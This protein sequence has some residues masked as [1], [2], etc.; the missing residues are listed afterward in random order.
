[1]K[2]RLTTYDRSLSVPVGYIG[3]MISSIDAVELPDPPQ[4]A[5]VIRLD[6]PLPSGE[7]IGVPFISRD[8]VCFLAD[9]LKS[10][11]DLVWPKEKS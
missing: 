4:L 3:V 1:M 2:S 6:I 8:E 5:V 9:R 11:A 10:M 7:Y